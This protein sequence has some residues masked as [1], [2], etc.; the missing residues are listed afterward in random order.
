MRKQIYVAKTIL[1]KY[2]TGLPGAL[3][4]TIKPTKSILPMRCNVDAPWISKRVRNKIFD[5]ATVLKTL[6]DHIDILEI[7][8][9]Y[10]PT[11]VYIASE[12]NKLVLVFDEVVTALRVTF[13]AAI[14]DAFDSPDTRPIR[15]WG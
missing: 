8:R 3:S 2:H 11:N 14:V 15:L 6:K 4:L 5:N 10:K 12:H 7:E 1:V 9:F 13:L